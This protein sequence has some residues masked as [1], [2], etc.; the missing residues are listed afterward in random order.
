M[1]LQEDI[2]DARKSAFTTV[3]TRQEA[4]IMRR[5]S[6]SSH[7]VQMEWASFAYQDGQERSYIVLEWVL[8]DKLVMHRGLSAA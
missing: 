6:G 1:C 3:D 4:A 2:R 7:V 8:K 5:M